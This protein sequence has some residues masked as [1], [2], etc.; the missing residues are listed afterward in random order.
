MELSYIAHHSHFDR[1]V[2]SRF[3]QNYLMAKC[4]YLKEAE[5]TVIIVT[6][7]TTVAETLAHIVDDSATTLVATDIGSL[8]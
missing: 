1:F 3:S 2:S 6:T 4:Y 7:D 5:A 8:H